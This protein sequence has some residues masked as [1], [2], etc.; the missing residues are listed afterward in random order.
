MIAG[1]SIAWQRTS[2][3]SRAIVPCSG[4][5]AIIRAIWK[6]SAD[7]KAAKPTNRTGSNIGSWGDR[8][9][10]RIRECFQKRHQ[11]TLLGSGEL[12]AGIGM[13]REIRIE[14]RAALHALIVV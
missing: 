3:R 10:T 9:E 8:F 14:V 2:W 4:S 12:Q 5:T 6:I 1:S 7:A 13:L 11:R